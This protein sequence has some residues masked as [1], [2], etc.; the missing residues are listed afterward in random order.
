[1]KLPNLPLEFWSKETLTKIGNSIGKFVYVDPW[2]RGEK[3]KR[4]AWILI[5]KLYKGGYPDHMEIVWGGYKIQQRLDF[6]GIPFRCSLCHKTGHLIKNC[7]HRHLRKNKKLN[8]RKIRRSESDYSL[9][10]DTRVIS[11]QD[12]INPSSSSQ[13]MFHIPLSQNPPSEPDLYCSFRDILDCHDPNSSLHICSTIPEPQEDIPIPSPPDKEQTDFV[14]SSLPIQIS[15]SS[16]TPVK[17]HPA[18]SKGKNPIT[19]QENDP[20]HIHSPRNR[21]SDS[22]PN[23]FDSDIDCLFNRTSLELEPLTIHKP[24]SP[25]HPFISPQ[26]AKN[27]TVRK[28]IKRG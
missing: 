4:I 28:K 17:I 22:T 9:D 26:S 15:S 3:D 8:G 24:S 14:V 10:F 21:L 20:C 7:I 11:K 5:E 27:I 13:K 16:P 1:M 6:W 12:T 18:E 23:N 2:C 25:S 19:I